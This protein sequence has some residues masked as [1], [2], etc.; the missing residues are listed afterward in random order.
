MTKA[1]TRTVRRTKRPGRPAWADDQAN[2]EAWAKRFTAI[3]RNT[4]GDDGTISAILGDPN[5]SRMCAVR[6]RSYVDEGSG[7]WLNHQRKTRRH[8]HK[9]L[10]ECAIEGLNAAIDL[11]Q[12]SGDQQGTQYLAVLALQFSAALGRS[13]QAFSVKRHGRDCPHS[14]LYEARAYLEARLGRDVT[15]PALADLVNAGY[16]ADG[17]APQHPVTEEQIRKNLTYFKRRNPIYCDLVARRYS[18][19]SSQSETKLP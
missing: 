3:L 7:D 16:E 15:Y 13:K 8:K 10:L 2:Q 18:Q 14:T 1:G 4:G 12:D 19:L 5:L 9:K 6:I 17:R 11:L